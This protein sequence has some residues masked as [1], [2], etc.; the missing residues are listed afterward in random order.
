MLVL[1]AQRFRRCASQG[2]V[3]RRVHVLGFLL[4][5][6][7]GVQGFHMGNGAT[8]GDIKLDADSVVGIVH[9]LP[10]CCV[11]YRGI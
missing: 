9:L 6:R 10:V 7:E 2:D 4:Q 8:I 3:Q 11:W 1:C 5:K